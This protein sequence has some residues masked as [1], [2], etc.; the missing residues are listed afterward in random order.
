MNNDLGGGKSNTTQAQTITY[1]RSQTP[2]KD[3]RA[4]SQLLNV[5][6]SYNDNQIENNKTLE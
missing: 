6:D 5:T 1:G 3:T 2:G 4:G